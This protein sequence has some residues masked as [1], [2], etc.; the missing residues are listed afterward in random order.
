MAEEELS[1]DTL[2]ASSP[3]D[4]Q[5][6][7]SIVRAFEKGAHHAMT[8][9]SVFA[10]LSPRMDAMRSMAKVTKQEMEDKSSGSKQVNLKDMNNPATSIA[11]ATNEGIQSPDTNPKTSLADKI[12]ECIPCKFKINFKEKFDIASLFDPLGVMNEFASALDKSKEDYFRRALAEINSILDM[13]RNLDKYVD[14]CAFRKFLTENVCVPDL[15]RI[16]AVLTAYLMKLALTLNSSFSTILTLFGGLLTPFLSSLVDQMMK[17]LM[18]AI[19]PIECVIES[20]QRFLTKIDYNVLFK[21][22][23]QLKVNTN[24]VGINAT[25]GLP[26]TGPIIAAKNREREDV[27]KA[28]ANLKALQEA[29]LAIDGGDQAA[30]DKNREQI[31]KAKQERNE[32]QQK[33]D[34]SA[35]GALNEGITE[36]FGAMKG[37]IVSLIGTLRKAVSELE[38][39]IKKLIDEFMKLLNEFMGSG[40]NQLD[41]LGNKLQIVQLMAMIVAIM[42]AIQTKSVCENEG[43][44]TERVLSQVNLNDKINIWTDEDG[45]IHIDD[46]NVGIDAIAKAFG[47]GD[48][49]RQ[50]FKGLVQ[51][52]GDKLLDSSISRAVDALVDP[53]RIKFKCPLQTSVASAEQVNRWISELDAETA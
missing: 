53:R 51:F 11:T 32:K 41:L 4:I 20:I 28:E 48:D 6:C 12:R 27:A 2:D 45:T 17:F 36:K 8:E 34:Q 30:A 50:K 25:V 15:Q 1:I 43:E 42:K 3:V 18:A 21:N 7:M 19:K 10:V 24:G 9:E 33:L 31:T 5:D 14:L 52:T 26:G 16:L 38:G 44:E 39:Y 13:F 37:S 29:S 35:V 47:L 40:A 49:P 23:D 46:G 22:I